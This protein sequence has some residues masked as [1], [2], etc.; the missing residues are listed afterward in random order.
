M[1]ELHGTIE[2]ITYESPD[3]RFVVARLA[4]EGGGPVLAITGP[5][6][7]IAAGESVR[8]TGEYEEHPRHGR[9]FRV[10]QAVPV[11]PAT[12]AGLERYLASG[13]VAGVGPALAQRLCA[14]FGVEVLAVAEEHPERLTEVDGVGPKRA[15]AIAAGLKAQ[16]AARE[17][18]VFLQG[19]GVSPGLAGRIHKVY[20]DDAIAITRQHP[21]RLAREVSGIGFAT[22]DRIAHGLG[23]AEDAPERIEAGLLHVLGDAEGEGHSYLPRAV[24]EERAAQVL[25]VDRDLCAAGLAGLTGAR[26]VVVEDGDDGEGVFTP[27]L[28]RAEV[29]LAERLRALRRAGRRAPAPI[30]ADLATLSD[31]QRRAVVLAATEPVA[32]LTGGPGT[33]KTTCLRAL[34]AA[35]A[36]A[37][38]PV[39]LCAP[40]GRAARRLTEASGAPARTVHRLLEYGPEGRFARTASNPLEAALVVCD[41]ASMLDLPLARSLASAVPEGA[42]LL[43]CGDAHQLPSVGPGNVLGDVIRSGRFPVVELTEIFRQA[44]GSG[45]VVNAHRIHR[46]ELPVPSRGDPTGGDFFVVSCEDPIRARDVVVRLCVERI[47]QAF[48]LHPRR[49]VQ[50]LTPMHRGEAGTESLNRALQEA[51]NPPAAGKEE[52]AH[53]SRVLRVGDKVMQVRNDYTRDVA[54]GDLGEIARIGDDGQVAVEID[55]RTVLYRPE[56]LGELEHAFAM[57]V[58]KSQGSE[59]PAVI[60]VLLP[61]HYV[62]L[63]RNLLYTAVTRAKRLVVLVGADRALRRAVRNAETQRRFTR[64]GERLREG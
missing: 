58:H 59:Y 49:D 17:V 55:G 44:A 4:P 14:R 41:E 57:S 36:A 37:G 16:R 35:H 61:Q 62:M 5:L 18:M 60:V 53:G 12:R 13:I 23:L 54:N 28:H 39:L 43:L 11:I 29:R 64:L 34:V 2:R 1:A 30:G 19:H 46:G 51:L 22:A 63:Q 48:G 31:G 21:F 45:I 15:A 32:V 3:G 25:E 7:G 9:Q 52:V 40:T 6:A 33:G 27:S 47:P 56:Q 8:L 42:T 50:V 24:L 10:T 38:L 20:G 26:A